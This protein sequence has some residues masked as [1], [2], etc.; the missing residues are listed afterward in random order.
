MNSNTPHTL[1]ASIVVFSTALFFFFEF[2]QMNMFNALDPYLMKAFSLSAAELGH[3]SAYYFYAVVCC[4]FPAGFL[5]D[6]YSTKRIITIAMLA[7]IICTFGFAFAQHFWQAA[8]CRFIT[9][10]AGA[11]CLLSCVRIASRWFPAKRMALVMGLVV[12][13]AMLGGMIAQT[14]FT[15]LAAHVG[16]RHTLVIDASF[17]ILVWLII[18]WGVIDYPPGSEKNIEK[19][20][21]HLNNLGIIQNIT[22]VAKNTQNWLAGLYTCLTNLSLMLL[23]A[24]WGSMYLTQVRHLSITDASVVTSMIF[25]GTIIGSP[26]M[27]WLSDTLKQRRKPMIFS[28]FL[29]LLVFYIIM[30]THILSFTMLC[31]LFFTLGFLTSAQ[32]IS[33]ALVAE[34]NSPA[35]TGSAEGFASVIIMSG[36]FLQPLFGWL[37]EQNWNHAYHNGVPLYSGADFR[38]AMLLMPISLII[39]IIIAF[40]VKETHCKPLSKKINDITNTT[41]LGAGD[42]LK[43]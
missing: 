7:C 5:L 30:Y 36:G 4:L 39:S 11:F 3:L 43:V 13:M 40:A 32:I 37:V 21:A 25:I 41:N 33:Y 19:D 18:M 6:R 9:G 10:V 8:L 12:T 15:V 29:A 20:Q 1:K 24:I 35:L 23:G 16:W 27:G 28:A 2:M 38:H 14:P 22:Q 42:S 17:G 31:G 34:S 26:F